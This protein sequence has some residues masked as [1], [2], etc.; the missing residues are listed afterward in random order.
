[1]LTWKQLNH[2][3]DR[4]F[5]RHRQL[6]ARFD[7]FANIVEQQVMAQNFHI[8]GIAVSKH[9]EQGFFT[10][11]F[12]LRTLHFAFTSVQD[13]S[14]M[15]MGNVKCYLKRELPEPECVV[16]G[17]FKFSGNGQTTLVEPEENDPLNI[18]N[19]IAAL[20]IVLNFIHKSLAR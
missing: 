17:D 9:L 5:N 3:L 14:G 1:M 18:D 15:L 10:T 8:K 12:A 19:D 4:A 16:I 7:N 2:D 6:T 13:E 20:F 11:A